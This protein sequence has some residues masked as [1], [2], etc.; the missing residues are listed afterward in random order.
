[1]RSARR[2]SPEYSLDN[3]TW[4]VVDLGKRVPI[5]L[6]VLLAYAVIAVRNRPLSAR[7]MLP[8]GLAALVIAATAGKSDRA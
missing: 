3:L 8:Y 1:M 7:L 5:L 2:C 4:Y 6:V